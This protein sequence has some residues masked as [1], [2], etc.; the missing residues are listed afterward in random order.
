MTASPA[1]RAIGDMRHILRDAVDQAKLG[2]EFSPNSYSFG[3]LSAC[4]AAEKAVDVLSGALGSDSGEDA[5]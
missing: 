2:Y 4:L 3:A 1:L 5:A